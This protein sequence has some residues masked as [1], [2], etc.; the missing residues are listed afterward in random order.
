MSKQSATK[1]RSQAN[2]APPE[3]PELQKVLDDL[4]GRDPEEILTTGQMVELT[5][6]TR[7]SFYNWIKRTVKPL[8]ATKPGREHQVRVGDLYEFLVKREFRE[9][10]A[11]DL[12][13]D[14]RTTSTAML[15]P[16]RASRLNTPKRAHLQLAPPQTETAPRAAARPIDTRAEAFTAIERLIIL[17][18]MV[19][20]WR[21]AILTA[22]AAEVSNDLEWLEQCEAE[23]VS[24]QESLFD[25]GSW[26]SGALLESIYKA[27]YA[28]VFPTEVLK[29]INSEAA[30]ESSL[31]EG[32]AITVDDEFL[33]KP[34]FE[35]FHQMFVDAFKN[36]NWQ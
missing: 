35:A 29:V 27:L 26:A 20:R 25:V 19:M 28:A 17:A 1:K 8:K 21:R 3:K 24:A 22:Q 32:W 16:A 11:G 9:G 30:I 34:D 7:Q 5:G 14:E 23:A 15:H 4:S 12:R 18:R 36:A 2:D 10:D 6:F 31:D 13:E 33:A